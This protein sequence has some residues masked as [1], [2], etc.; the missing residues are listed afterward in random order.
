MP[1]VTTETLA[2]RSRQVR[3]AIDHCTAPPITIEELKSR[4][5][6]RPR[7]DGVRAVAYVY[8]PNARHQNAPDYAP[9]FALG[10][11]DHESPTLSLN[12]PFELQSIERVLAELLDEFPATAGYDVVLTTIPMTGETWPAG[13]KADYELRE[14]HAKARQTALAEGLRH[15]WYAR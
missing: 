10:V 8:G 15:V 3:F 5:A 13:L 12:G 4:I 1:I 2:T 7:A 11:T 9:H 14:C 6:A